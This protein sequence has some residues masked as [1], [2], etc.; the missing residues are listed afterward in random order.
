PFILGRQDESTPSAKGQR[1]A[2]DIDC[3]VE[4]LTL[5]DLQQ[6]ALWIGVL[7]MQPSQDAPAGKGKIVLDEFGRQTELGIAALVPGLHEE[8]ARIA[9]DFGFENEQAGN[10]AR[11]DIHGLE[12]ESCRPSGASDVPE[13]RGSWEEGRWFMGPTLT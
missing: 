12:D 6:L 1:T 7:V 10:F 2:A 3:H 11:D 9:E 4:H 5:E 8:A 13:S